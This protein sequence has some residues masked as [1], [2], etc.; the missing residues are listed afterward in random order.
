VTHDRGTTTE[1]D[2]TTK[3]ER[4]RIT[5]KNLLFSLTTGIVLGLIAGA[6]LGWFT[7]RMYSQQRAGQILLCRQKHIGQPEVELK[8]LCG[9]P[10]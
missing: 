7:H 6:P 3:P 10:Y 9:E 5:W 4:Q 2:R 8:A 1:Y